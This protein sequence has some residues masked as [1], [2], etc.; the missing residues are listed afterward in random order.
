[1]LPAI[2][3]QVAIA[4]KQPLNL[5]LG[6]D[7]ARRRIMMMVNGALRAAVDEQSAVGNS[8][9]KIGVLVIGGGKYRVESSECNKQFARRDETGSRAIIHH[10]RSADLFAVNRGVMPVERPAVAPDERAYFL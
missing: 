2:E 6:P 7:L 5:C 10:M 1:M 9:C 3:E 4:L 8:K